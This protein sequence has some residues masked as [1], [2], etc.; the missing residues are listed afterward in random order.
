LTG[1]RYVSAWSFFSRSCGTKAV[2][3]L[4]G[5]IDRYNGIHVD[6]GAAD[7]PSDRHFVTQLKGIDYLLCVFLYFIDRTLNIEF[8]CTPSK[9]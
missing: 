7:V 5:H 4:H 2:S 1:N 9:I 3:A 6:I 8:F